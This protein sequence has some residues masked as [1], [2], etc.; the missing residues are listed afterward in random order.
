M[1]YTRKTYAWPTSPN[2]GVVRLVNPARECDAMSSGPPYASVSTI[3]PP[4]SPSAVERTTQTPSRSRATSMVGLAKNDRSSA[5]SGARTSAEMADIG[6]KQRPEQRLDPWHQ[7]AAQDACYLR[8]AQ[9][10]VIL[11]NLFDLGREGAVGR[12]VVAT[13]RDE[14]AAQGQHTH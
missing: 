7:G 1:P 8:V 13:Q 6:R 10:G 4:L 9:R 11:A 12:G 3:G 5:L 2:M 14:H